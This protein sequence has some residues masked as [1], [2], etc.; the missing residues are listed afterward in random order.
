[1]RNNG[2][3]T[4]QEYIVPEGA[5]LVSTTDLNSRITYCNP[6]FIAVSGYRREE[7]IGQP[8]NMIR[9]PDM[10]QEA[11]RDMWATIESGEPW[12][13]MVKNRRKNGDHYWVV[14]NVTPVL[15]GGEVA[16][17]MSVR[18]GVTREQVAAAEALYAGMREEAEAGRL[19]TLL[20]RGRLRSRTSVGRLRSMFEWD[21]SSRTCP[22]LER[23]MCCNPGSHA[24]NARRNPRR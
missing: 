21:P 20:H 17:Y 14:A 19:V 15:E 9:H 12:S 7:L 16:G 3:I 5:T 8:H 23:S 22:L 6:S 18:T 11:F 24:L 2:P 10:P 4:Q 1:M 13:A